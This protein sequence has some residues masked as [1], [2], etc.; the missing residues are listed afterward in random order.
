MKILVTGRHGQLACCL[1][2]RVLSL[3]HVTLLHAARPD[4]DLTDLASIPRIVERERPDIIVSAAAY[5][6]VDAAQDEPEKAMLVNAEAA[7]ILARSAAAVDAPI[8]H[9]STDYVFSGGKDCAYIEADPADPQSVYGKSKYDGELAVAA[10]NE[11]HVI[12][13]TAWVH[14]PYG[15]NFVKTMLRL[16]QERD[17]IAIVADQTGCPT[18]A[19][20]LA[21]A[22]L[23]VAGVIVRREN[24]AQ[25]GTFH[26]VG[27]G[28]VNWADFAREIFRLSRLYGGPWAEVR[29]I[30]S[31][32]YP[33]KAPRPR[34]SVLDCGKLQ[35][36]YGVSLPDWRLSLQP[37]VDKLTAPGGMD[38]A[39]K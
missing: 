32:E 8:I 11:R 16:G 23:H 33:Q 22:V 19:S 25:F 39:E 15:R 1:A 36:V 10:E 7:G 2:E 37:I 21:D 18:S 30:A 13:R 26:A 9:I 12:L 3:D 24:V 34:N 17:V 29:N 4:M 38:H 20:D 31:S 35:S 6:N 5:T 14:S 28:S 27:N